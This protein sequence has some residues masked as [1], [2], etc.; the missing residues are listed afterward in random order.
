MNNSAY[1]LRGP[2]SGHRKKAISQ[3]DYSP[4][5]LWWRCYIERYNQRWDTK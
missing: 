4:Y 1:K 5:T 2:I 3:S